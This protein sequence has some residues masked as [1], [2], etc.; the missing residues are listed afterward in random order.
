MKKIITKIGITAG[1]LSPL[2]TFAEPKDLQYV[3]DIALFY[4]KYG[5]YLIMGLAV[6]MFVWNI[7]KYFIKGGDNVGDKKDA[8]L[9]VMWSVI[10]FFVILSMWGLVKI[11][12]NTFNLDSNQ[13]SEFFGSFRSST[14]S[15][16]GTFGG[17]KTNIGGDV[18]TN[19]GTPIDTGNTS[20]QNQQICEIGRSC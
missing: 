14:N 8:G 12:T 9:Y 20:L 19:I 16:L 17:S 4:F 5:I 10:G 3:I 7:F 11:V 13:P 2:I 1:L 18:K 6:V 15:N